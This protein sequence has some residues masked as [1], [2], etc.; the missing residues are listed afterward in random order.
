MK[1]PLP[2][3]KPAHRM[4][5]VDVLVKC[6]TAAGWHAVLAES[7]DTRVAVAFEPGP[8]PQVRRPRE[9]P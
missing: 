3:P 6:A 2:A 7:S 1:P 4:D 5:L 9:T 8:K